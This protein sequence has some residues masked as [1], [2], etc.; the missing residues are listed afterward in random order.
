MIYFKVKLYGWNVYSA[1]IFL[2]VQKFIYNMSPNRRFFWHQ[3]QTHT[4]LFLIKHNSDGIGR[5]L[6]VLKKGT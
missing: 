5:T 6:I 4:S 3:R 2:R 1:I